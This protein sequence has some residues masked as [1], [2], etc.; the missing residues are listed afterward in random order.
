M[1]ITP[2]SLPSAAGIEFGQGD[3]RHFAQDDAVDVPSLQNPTRQLAQRDNM[4]ASKV[5]ELVESVNNKE[6][7]VPLTIPR[8][9]ITPGTE[10]MVSNFAIPDGFEARVLS[11]RIG[12]NPA[13]ADLILKIYYAPGPTFGQSTGTELVSTSDE[14]DSGVAFYNNGEFIISV[15]NNGSADREAVVS[16]TL[17]IRPLGSTASLLVGSTVSGP[18]GYPGKDGG[19]GKKGDPGPGGAGSPG[20]V[21]RGQ[22][23]AG[24]PSAGDTGYKPPDVVSFTDTTQNPP[25]GITSSYISINQNPAP[26]QPPSAANTSPP[27]N[28]NDPA[29]LWSPVAVGSAGPAGEAAAWKGKWQNPAPPAP[30]TQYY[31]NN[32]VSYTAT[33]VNQ[34]TST[35]I[36]IADVASATPPITDTQHWQVAVSGGGETPTYYNNPS[37]KIRA[38]TST[39]FV[40]GVQDLPYEGNPLTPMTPPLGTVYQFDSVHEMGLFNSAAVAVGAPKNLLLLYGQGKYVF[41]G[42]VQVIMPQKDPTSPPTLDHATI[43][44]D[45]TTAQCI[46]TI[47]DQENNLDNTVQVD[48]ARVSPVAPIAPAVP[49]AIAWEVSVQTTNP[50]KVTITVLGMLVV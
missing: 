3:V 41:K 40:S 29:A 31:K 13:S 20:M 28:K 36:C 37:I 46:V 43:N 2:I 45:T 24:D 14:F 35:Y 17:T 30:P 22:F 47:D 19:P 33:G 34:P 48:I 42:K 9:T 27:L 26:A 21:W 50:R 7:F 44:W 18:R 23:A 49:P 25:I 16:I 12:S 6:Q 8:T 4:L 10:E 32:L 15:H 1:D 11:A 39:G 5:N 38:I